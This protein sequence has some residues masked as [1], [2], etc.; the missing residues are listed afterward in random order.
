MTT[1]VY[2]PP[3]PKIVTG[4][5]PY[6]FSFEFEAA[7]E[8]AVFVFDGVAMVALDAEVFMVSPEGGGQGGEVQLTADAATIWDQQELFIRRRTEVVQDW[9][10][11]F[12]PRE[13][14]LRVS[15]DRIARGVQE[16]REGLERSVTVYSGSVGALVPASGRALIWSEDELALVPGPNAE[17]IASA[18]GHAV[19]AKDAAD[20]VDLGAL[21]EAVELSQQSSEQA[22]Q[23]ASASATAQGLSEAARGASEAAQGL[24]EVAQ[25]LSEVARDEALV[26]AAN[27]QSSA[28]TLVDWASLVALTG[29]VDGEGAEVLDSDGGT[30]LAASATGYDGAAVNNAGRYS[31][32]AAWGRWERIGDT[33]LTQKADKTVTGTMARVY[34]D[35][36][37][38]RAGVDRAV[39]GSDRK[40]IETKKDDV[41]EYPGA[42][43]VKGRLNGIYFLGRDGRWDRC[44]R[45]VAV[46]GSDRKLISAI[47]PEPEYS[48]RFDRCGQAYAMVGSNRRALE[49][50][51]PIEVS[52]PATFAAYIADDAG[53]Q[54]VF[55]ENRETGQRARVSEA[56]SN[57]SNLFLDG[58]GN[59]VWTSTDNSKGAPGTQYFSELSADGAEHAYRPVREL[60]CWGDS[61][62]AQNWMAYLASAG[63][64]ITSH[65]FGKSADTSTAIASRMGA[66]ENLYQVEGGAIPA[67]TDPV[68][69]VRVGDGDPLSKFGGLD[70]DVTGWL[71]G[72]WGTLTLTAGDV[73]FSR[74]S[75]GD[76][77]SVDVARFDWGQ[78]PTGDTD[79][80][81]PAAV[82]G[83]ANDCVQVFFMGRN[84]A[85][86][87][88]I[89]QNHFRAMVNS[90]A[91]YTK[92]F[93]IIPYL[94][95]R[96]EPA[97]SGEGATRQL[98]VDSLAAEWPDNTLDLLP[99]MLAAYDPGDPQDVIDVGNGV[100]PSTLMQSDGLHP[101]ENGKAVEAQAFVD[102]VNEKGTLL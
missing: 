95:S 83:Y 44:G 46:I 71:A 45:G 14:P 62:T 82:I 30:H 92:R 85:R 75:A 101:N 41:I 102:F 48:P 23:S 35:G 87:I 74:M 3:A 73:T 10:N 5:G 89:I 17:E 8:I 77:V 94:P 37:W 1:D 78:S 63:L 34:E 90:I 6:P 100:P 24:S 88:E 61:L 91:S 38:A 27:A 65:N 36:R 76:A 7:A 29:S 69:L 2:N 22:G 18:Q 53:A 9:S 55:L 49:K 97:A 40:T 21:D 13:L 16:L 80:T 98:L 51:A 72:V 64:S 50:E 19:A 81:D 58:L 67:T 60:A 47:L 25:G 39:I 93:V 15:L 68:N 33:G 59:A 79:G 26:A 28:R 31:W 57:C 20:R 54:A 86:S 12:N 56:G 32:I 96:G 66:L 99:A 4:V 43:N 70:N 52:Q 11:G 42:V 84:N